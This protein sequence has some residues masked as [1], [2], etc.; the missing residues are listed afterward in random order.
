M[1][2]AKQPRHQKKSQFKFKKI[3]S[4]HLALRGMLLNED[5]RSWKLSAAALLYSQRPS[6]HRLDLTAII[7]Q[8]FLCFRT[9]S[10]MFVR[11]V[12]Q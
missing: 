8:L 4:E 2:G 12:A 1:S 3:I 9:A 6:D 11:K 10:G 5:I 7:I